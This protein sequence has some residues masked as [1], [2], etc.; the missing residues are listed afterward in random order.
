MSVPRDTTTPR[1][2]RSGVAPP[3]G[4]APA[5]LPSAD[6]DADADIATPGGGAREWLERRGLP[7]PSSLMR[8]LPN[9]TIDQRLDLPN[10]KTGI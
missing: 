4:G 5:A 9:S 6:N 10:L 1:S 7:N 2:R 8:S 3:P